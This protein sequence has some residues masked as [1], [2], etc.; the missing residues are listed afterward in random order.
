MKDYRA[1]ALAARLRVAAAL[2]DRR[3]VARLARASV[4][5]LVV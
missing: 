4:A 2:G 5:A 1:I 3:A